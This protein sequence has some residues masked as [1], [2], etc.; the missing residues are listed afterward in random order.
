MLGPEILVRSLTA[1]RVPDKFGNVWQYH[2]RSD[3]H[4]KIACW[5]TLF[6][7]LRECPLLVSHVATGRVAFGINHTLRQFT[8]N[9]PKNLDLVLCLPRRS[10]PPPR[11]ARTFLTMAT[12]YGVVLT[13]EERQ[14]LAGLPALAEQPVGRV[15]A[16]MEAKA[17][18]TAHR[19]AGPRLYDELN[20]SLAAIHGS[21]ED[22]IAVGF[23][24]VNAATAFRS[25]D[26]NKFPL[27]ERPPVVN[28]HTQP[29]AAEFTQGKIA[30]L[31]LRSHVAQDG[32]DAFGITT[33]IAAND[34]TPISLAPSPP[35]LPPGHAF[36]YENMILRIAAI[37]ASR[38]ATL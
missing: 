23:L 15:L 3:R 16:A 25:T 1:Q 24:M 32:F 6:D 18:M 31:P 4:S 12:D 34:G 29:A 20:S 19:K 14:V 37:Y 5:A 33:V 21:A 28:R 26:N 35:A 2:S 27:A 38:F 22:A 11:Q 7:V 30:Q 13:D 10:E 9:R 17:C 36:H 8:N